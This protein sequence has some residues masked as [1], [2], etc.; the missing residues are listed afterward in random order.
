MVSHGTS[1]EGAVHDAVD[2]ECIEEGQESVG[3]ELSE[4]VAGICQPYPVEERIFE[5]GG[6]RKFLVKE[7]V[8]KDWECCE[9]GVVA[10]V[11]PT[12]VQGLPT[13]SRLKAVPI[14]WKHEESVLVKHVCYEQGVPPVS[15]SSVVEG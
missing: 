12:F 2:E 1:V 9:H 6:L 5:E 8:P 4:A 13:E 10:L 14:L 15:L 11:D 3:V 7:G